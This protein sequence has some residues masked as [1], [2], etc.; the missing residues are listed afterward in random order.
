MDN[1]EQWLN[2][3]EEIKQGKFPLYEK[4][5]KKFKSKILCGKYIAD[6]STLHAY[7]A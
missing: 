6:P 3:E 2:T 1:Y 4:L 5:D 7:G